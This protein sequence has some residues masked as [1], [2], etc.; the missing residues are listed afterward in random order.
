MTSSLALNYWVHQLWLSYTCICSYVAYVIGS[1]V[2]FGSKTLN[3][4]VMSKEVVFLLRI[5]EDPISD[6]LVPLSNDKFIS[7][8]PLDED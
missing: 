7:L 5:C 6:C 4:S 8:A 1:T 3:I 2:L